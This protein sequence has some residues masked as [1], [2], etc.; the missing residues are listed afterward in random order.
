MEM[1]VVMVVVRGERCCHGC[2]NGGDDM[3]DVVII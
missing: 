3:I 1:V 2:E